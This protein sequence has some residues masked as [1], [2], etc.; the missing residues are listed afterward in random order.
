MCAEPAGTGANTVSDSD[1]VLLG[2]G[3]GHV[4][5]A[6]V[7]TGVLVDLEPA[8]PGLEGLQQRARLRGR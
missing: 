5:G 8:H 1:V 2:H 3:Q 4:E 6:Q 7:R